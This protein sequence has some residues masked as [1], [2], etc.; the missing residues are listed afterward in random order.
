MHTF[1]YNANIKL[2]EPEADE[3][4]ILSMNQLQPMSIKWQGKRKIEDEPDHISNGNMIVFLD[5]YNEVVYDSN[6]RELTSNLGLEV[7]KILKEKKAWAMGS[8]IPE[9]ALQEVEQARKQVHEGK[10]NAGED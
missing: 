1:S 3:Y 10:P 2:K 4:R 5:F 6:F 7:L 8:H 9:D